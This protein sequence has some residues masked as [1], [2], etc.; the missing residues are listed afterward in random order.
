MPNCR[1]GR[2]VRRFS[3]SRWPTGLEEELRTADTT[4]LVPCLYQEL[5][6]WNEIA[7]VVHRREIDTIPQ[8]IKQFDLPR[9]QA[10]MAQYRHMWTYNFTCQYIVSRLRD[11][12]C[13]PVPF[14]TRTDMPVTDY[15]RGYALQ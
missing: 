4:E 9:A 8:R 11:E 14:S 7:I 10:L 6:N 12:P 13:S 1:G 3:G 5:I 2:L 15:P